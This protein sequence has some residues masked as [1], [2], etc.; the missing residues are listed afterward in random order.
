L[1]RSRVTLLL[2]ILPQEMLGTSMYEY[3]HVDDIAALTESHKAALQSTETLTTAVR[4]FSSRPRSSS[5]K[6][7][8][9]CS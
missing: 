4:L 7:I 9:V 8:S 2:G 1:N 6:L 5:M 3:Y